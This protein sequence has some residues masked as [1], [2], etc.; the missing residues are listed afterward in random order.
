MIAH[1]LAVLAG[2]ITLCLAGPAAPAAETDLWCDQ[3]PGNRFFWTEWGFCDLSPHGPHAAQG[4]VIWNHG[5][6]GTSEQFKA[7]PAL[8]LRILHARGWDVVKLNRHNLGETASSLARAA[9]RTEEEIR[10]QRSRGYRRVVLAGQSFGGYVSLETAADRRNVFAVVAL[11]P[12]VSSRGGIDRIDPSVTE[13][14]LADS[15]A[16]TASGSA[17]SARRW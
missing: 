16:A 14:L 2:L 17:C 7:P 9:A 3:A 13:R 15:K 11:A 4:I 12:G 10:V 1:R 5:I 6:S 8:A